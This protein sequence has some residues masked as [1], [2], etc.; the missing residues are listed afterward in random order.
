MNPT[1]MRKENI[2]CK[3]FSCLVTRGNRVY[4]KRGID[5]HDD[6][7][8][9]FQKDD[10]NLNDDKISPFNTFARIEITPPDGNYLNTD[11]LKWK[12][13]IDEKIKPD[14]LSPEHESLCRAEMVIWVKEIQSFLNIEEIKNP[15]HPFK[16]KPPDKITEEH[17]FLLKK[18][19]FVLQSIRESFEDS[20]LEPIRESFLDSI[21]DSIRY[22]VWESIG[23]SVFDSFGSFFLNSLRDSVEYSVLN[24]LREYVGV[25]FWAYI[26]TM[27]QNIEEWKYIDYTNPIFQKGEYPFQAA[28]DLWK[29]GLV[30]VFDYKVWK[31]HGGPRANILWE[32]K[33]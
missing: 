33:I 32:G 29:L 25:F 13:T 30:P 19:V 12:Y 28:A 6:I 1:E 21:L 3:A 16:I 7:L 2:M 20:V 14:F 27:F 11:F 18:W 24:S 8:K 5:S 31:L 22:S 9:F 10:C 17:L 26:G 15:I 23:E 4:W